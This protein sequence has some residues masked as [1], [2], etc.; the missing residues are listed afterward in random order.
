MVEP[1][2]VQLVPELNKG[3]IASLTPAEFN[4]IDKGLLLDYLKKYKS[5]RLLR[6]VLNISS[7]ETIK[8]YCEE[9]LKDEDL[10]LN[11]EGRF[12]GRRS[13]RINIKRKGLRRRSRKYK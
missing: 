2:W 11:T 3:F 10:E 7:D 8:K 13:R 12:G 5:A 9:G 6:R 4:L 1:E